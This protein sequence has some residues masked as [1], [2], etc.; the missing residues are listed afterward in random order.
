MFFGEDRVGERKAERYAAAVEFTENLTNKIN[1]AISV[2]IASAVPDCGR[3]HSVYRGDLHSL[4]EV[5]G[6]LSEHLCKDYIES[7]MLGK[8][9]QMK[10]YFHG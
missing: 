1:A 6:E 7:V 5:F 10:S 9:W 3:E 2:L 4:A 8:I